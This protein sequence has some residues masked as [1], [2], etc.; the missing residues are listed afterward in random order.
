MDTGDGIY[1]SVKLIVKVV[2][3]IIFGPVVLAI[4]FVVLYSLLHYFGVNLS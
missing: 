2:L 3:W 4:L 1:K